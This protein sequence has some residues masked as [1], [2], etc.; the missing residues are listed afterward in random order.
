MI[1]VLHMVLRI[2]FSGVVLTADPR[3]MELIDFHD[4]P[5]TTAFLIFGHGMGRL[6]W[7]D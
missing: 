1:Y 2:C 5:L 6:F 4:P 3:M 7:L